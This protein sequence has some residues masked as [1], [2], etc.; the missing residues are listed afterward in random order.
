M[1][2]TLYPDKLVVDCNEDGFTEEN[3]SA[4]CDVGN[5]SKSGSQG[6]IGEKG[7]GFKSVFMA[8][9]KVHIQSGHLSFS[10]VH[11]RGDSGMGMVKPIWEEPAG[12]LPRENYTRI[13][14]FLHEGGD[15]EQTRREREDVREQFRELEP[16]L[17]LFV[18]RLRC[19]NVTFCN[20]QGRQTWATSLMRH[21]AAETGRAV[22]EKRTADGGS[23][24]DV[25]PERHIYHITEHTAT[26]VARHDNR[27]LSASDRSSPASRQ[28]KIVLAFPVS[29]ESV[30]IIEAQKVFAF[31]PMKQMGFNV[32]WD[33][34]F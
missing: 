27:E 33:S 2:F 12:A 29:A 4:I 15:A 17:L 31:L 34:A 16:A 7:I 3:L 11:R 8:A 21:Q 24:R 20:G 18:G 23:V 1:S 32:S 9:W 10:F 6:Y 25:A 5:S 13:T 26:N 28:S 22:L 19:V 14:L 30:P